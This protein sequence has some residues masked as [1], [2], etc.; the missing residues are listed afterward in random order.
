[1]R[2]QATTEEEFETIEDYISEVDNEE[3]YTIDLKNEELNEELN[4]NVSYRRIVW[5]D[6]HYVIE[7]NEDEFAAAVSGPF[8]TI[9]EAEAQ[10]QKDFDNDCEVGRQIKEEE[11]E[12]EEDENLKDAA[13]EERQEL[14]YEIEGLMRQR[15]Y[16]IPDAGKAVIDKRVSE[17]K[18]RLKYLDKIINN[19]DSY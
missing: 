15:W 13:R 6:A 11:E 9:E 14:E 12:K 16:T 17:I 2:T 19:D 3:L 5:N 7:S 4:I 8:A 10:A 1:M 18:D